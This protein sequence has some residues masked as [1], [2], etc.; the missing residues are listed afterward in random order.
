MQRSETASEEAQVPPV[1][2]AQPERGEE[3]AT[4]GLQLCPPAPAAAALPA[5]ADP[6]PAAAAAAATLQL[7]DHPAR[8][9]QVS[10]CS[11][12]CPGIA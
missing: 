9:H 1:H 11:G 10:R 6:E 7:P 2:S 12:T 8:T 5:A 3:R 4:H